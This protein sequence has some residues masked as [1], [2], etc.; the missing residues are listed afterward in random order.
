VRAWT[1]YNVLHACNSPYVKSDLG[2][3]GIT[4]LGRTCGK[5][6]FPTELRAFV[7]LQAGYVG[8]GSTNPLP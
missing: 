3:K 1:T 5:V 6:G 8:A 7:V 4:A 2:N